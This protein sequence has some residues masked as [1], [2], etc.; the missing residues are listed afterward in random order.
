MVTVLLSGITR[1]EK[2]ASSW[3]YLMTLNLGS[4][5]CEREGYLAMRI[6]WEPVEKPLTERRSKANL[7]TI[8]KLRI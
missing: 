8:P 4:Y 6:T 5:R 3:F 2:R 7:L 1:G